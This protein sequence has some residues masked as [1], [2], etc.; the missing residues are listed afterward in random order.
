MRRIPPPHLGPVCNNAYKKKPNRWKK[1]I[2]GLAATKM[3]STFLRRII[4]IARIPS[5]NKYPSINYSSQLFYSDFV[6]RCR[7]LPTDRHTPSVVDC[8]E[9]V[10]RVFREYVSGLKHVLEIFGEQNF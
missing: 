2:V 7:L 4:T 5:A 10:F 9:Q 1:V 3:Q 8:V 6:H